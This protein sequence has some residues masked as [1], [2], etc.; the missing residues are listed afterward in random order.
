[1]WHSLRTEML[2]Q[3]T[4]KRQVLEE[5][6]RM[7]EVLRTTHGMYGNADGNVGSPRH[8]RNQP[9]VPGNAVGVSSGTP[10]LHTEQSSTDKSLLQQPV[11]LRPGS[12][13]VPNF[14]SSVHSSEGRRTNSTNNSGNTF[15][16]TNPDGEPPAPTIYNAAS[17]RYS[18]VQEEEDTEV[19]LAGSDTTG[20][21][22][23][24]SFVTAADEAVPA[25]T[26]YGRI[27]STINSIGGLIG[28]EPIVQHDPN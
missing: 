11:V 17:G 24:T 7:S 10:L 4:D 23:N 2:Q 14:R 12:G 20:R 27:G 19:V 28:F 6:A 18:L 25:P 9:V 13:I 1:M 3:L 8:Q 21:M 22:S 16:F 15:V 26:W 5:Q